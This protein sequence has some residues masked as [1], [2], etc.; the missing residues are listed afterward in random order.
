MAAICVINHITKKAKFNIQSK[1]S[2]YIFR[3]FC[4]S[5]QAIRK[6]KNLERNKHVKI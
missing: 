2:N 6:A 1:P 5:N 4:Y 3:L